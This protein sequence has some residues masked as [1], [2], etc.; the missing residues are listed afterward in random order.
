M[1]SSSLAGSNS[2]SSGTGVRAGEIEAGLTVFGVWLDLL[3]SSS[4]RSMEAWE[5]WR[6]PFISWEGKRGCDRVMELLLGD[7]AA[8]PRSG[9]TFFSS[10]CNMALAL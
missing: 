1:F 4:I 3:T 6:R 8:P 9:L 2:G 7:A 5:G 10:C